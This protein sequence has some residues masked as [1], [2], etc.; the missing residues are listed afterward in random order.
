MKTVASE[1][2][3]N[4]R[5]GSYYST[6]NPSG[7]MEVGFADMTINHLMNRSWILEHKRHLLMS[8]Y[9][10]ADLNIQFD[11]IESIIEISRENNIPLA[12]IGVSSP[13]MKHLPK[14]IKGLDLIIC[15]KDE[16]QTYFQTQEDDANKLC[17]MWLSGGV[18]KVVVTS[19]S[20]GAYYGEK[21]E[22]S[23]QDAFIIPKDQIIDVTGAGDAFSSATILGIT[24]NRSLK[25]SVLWGTANAS[26]TIKTKYAVNPKLSL[27]L[28]KKEIEK[29]D[30]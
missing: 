26:L 29:N 27:K 23:H 24:Q 3:K 17:T 7:E 13:K 4:E 16:S 28:I 12:I 15:N 22:V 30:K 1:T 9:I 14:D 2:I 10:V 20:K 18:K 21:D 11:G 6:I 19:G 25:E 8:S 5:T